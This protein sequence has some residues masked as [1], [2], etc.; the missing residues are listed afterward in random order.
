MFTSKPLCEVCG[1]RPATAFVGFRSAHND[2][3]SQW[4]FVCANEP[5]DESEAFSIADTF[6]SPSAMVERLAH[7]H[8]SGRVDWQ[9]FMDMI[10]RFHSSIRP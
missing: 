1:S 7:L 10:V 3:V 5:A 6:A 4:K 2:K 9:P 8:Q